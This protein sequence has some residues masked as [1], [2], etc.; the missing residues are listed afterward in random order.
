MR[1][2]E[3]HQRY[4]GLYLAK[5]ADTGDPKHLGRIRV[6]AD[7]FEDDPGDPVWASVARP[8]AG[9]ATNVFFTPQKGDQVIIGYLVGDVDEPIVLGYAHCQETPPSKEVD[10]SKHGIVTA[11]GRVVFDE[12]AKSITITFTGGTE[13]SIKL[14]DDGI[15]IRGPSVS[16]EATDPTKKGLQLTSMSA[17]GGIQ[18]TSVGPVAVSS[19]TTLSLAAP[20]I[21]IAGVPQFGAYPPSVPLPTTPLPGPVAMDFGGRPVCINNERVVMQSFISEYYNNHVHV[22]TSPPIPA[23][24]GPEAKCEP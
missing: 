14:S 16:I 5:V 21:G 18:Q 17:V 24:P 2:G 1:T 9:K 11:V 3:L 23:I 13:S 15:E 4:F 19:T 10:E 7:Q 22:T 12:V 8:A 20:V 6:E